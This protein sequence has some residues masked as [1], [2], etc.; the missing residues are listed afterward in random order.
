MFGLG[1]A[2]KIYVALGA[3]DMRKG[4]DGLYGM[5]RDTLCFRSISGAIRADV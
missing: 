4:F 1:P 5:I 3:T 2:T